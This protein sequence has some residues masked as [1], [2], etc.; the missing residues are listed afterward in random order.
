MM[1]GAESLID[2]VE[3]Q[4]AKFPLPPEEP[5]QVVTSLVRQVVE[6]LAQH[7]NAASNENHFRRGFDHCLADFSK[8]LR[9]SKLD[10]H[11][12]RV[13]VPV[14]EID[15][16]GQ[17]IETK[18]SQ[19][20]RASTDSTALQKKRKSAISPGRPSRRR[21]S[22]PSPER[23]AYSL[24]ELN[25]IYEIGATNSIPGSINDQVTEQLIRNSCSDWDGLLENLL[26][27]V[28]TLVGGIIG[29]SVKEAVGEWS[30]SRVYRET[31]DALMDYFNTKMASQSEAINQQLSS[32]Q[33]FPTT[34][35]SEHSAMKMAHREA[36]AEQ[37]YA[38]PQ[39]AR[40]IM[41]APNTASLEELIKEVRQLDS[42]W[43]NERL[44]NDG[45]GHI[46]DCVATVYTFHDI[47]SSRFADSV[48]V[49]LKAGVLKKLRKDTAAMLER[50]LKVFD[51]EHC[52]DLL[53]QDPVREK[54]RERLIGKKNKLEQAFRLL[55]NMRDSETQFR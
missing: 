36:F 15:S 39:Y 41:A 18:S 11:M 50:A 27:D 29:D 40:T 26:D 24:A 33:E 34:F 13:P 16:N 19:T 2:N 9:A 8:K 17:D 45:Y 55:K 43:V 4:L 12:D 7:I 14:V 1:R 47:M 21:S 20:G 3:A 42:K 51:A 44:A 49:G 10:V 53:A 54:E 35:S 6:C 23:I 37:R 46:I 38:R 30:E 48:S 5:N 52:A 25:E 32:M 28:S 31:K 22:R